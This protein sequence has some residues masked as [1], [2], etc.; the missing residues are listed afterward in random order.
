MRK[1]QIKEMP[2]LSL[3]LF[4]ILDIDLENLSGVYFCG[5]EGGGRVGQG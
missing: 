4:I 1:I 3:I 2:L 5:G